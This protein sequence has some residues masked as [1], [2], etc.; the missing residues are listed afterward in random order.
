MALSPA[1]HDDATRLRNT[2]L[3]GMASGQALADHEIKFHNGRHELAVD[4]WIIFKECCVEEAAKIRA[5]PDQ[6]LLAPRSS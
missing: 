4:A 2:L 3:A 5:A 6:E 1:E